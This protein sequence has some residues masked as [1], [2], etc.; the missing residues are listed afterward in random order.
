MTSGL[1]FY[2]GICLAT[3]IGGAFILV[4]WGSRP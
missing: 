1:A 3:V 4:K 2:C